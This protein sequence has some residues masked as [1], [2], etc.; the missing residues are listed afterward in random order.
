MAKNVKFYILRMI[1][2]VLRNIKN[3]LQI[4]PLCIFTRSNFFLGTMF[5]I[6]KVFVSV[7]RSNGS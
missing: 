6:Q 4:S 1:F 3:Q 2:G 7:S 5:R